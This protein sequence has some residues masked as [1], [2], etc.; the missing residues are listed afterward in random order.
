MKGIVSESCVRSWVGQMLEDGAVRKDSEFCEAGMSE[1]DIEMEG[2][3]VAVRRILTQKG[4]LLVM[5]ASGP[6]MIM[7]DPNYDD[8]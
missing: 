1:E 7:R 5:N 4:D 8:E 2:L 6:Y 3:L